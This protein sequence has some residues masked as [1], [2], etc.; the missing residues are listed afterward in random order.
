MNVRKATRSVR[1]CPERC[2]ERNHFCVASATFTKATAPKSSPGSQIRGRSIE[3]TRAQAQ[4]TVITVDRRRS[5]DIPA[6]NMSSE[7]D[8]HKQRQRKNYPQT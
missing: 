7:K 3:T 1:T 6:R 4:L 5:I 8:L 2:G